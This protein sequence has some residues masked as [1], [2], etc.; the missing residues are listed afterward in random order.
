M[1]KIPTI[2]INLDR[3]PH[4][5]RRFLFNMTLLRSRLQLWRLPAID[6]TELKR[7]QQQIENL[8]SGDALYRL[9]QGQRVAK[10]D[11]PSSGAIGCYLSHLMALRW[12]E[13][14][15][16]EGILILED[17]VVFRA[18]RVARAGMSLVKRIMPSISEQDGPD[19]VLLGYRNKSADR[20]WPGT[21]I[22]PIK[23]FFGL[24]AYYV[25]KQGATKILDSQCLPIAMQIDGHIGCLATCGRLNVQG[26]TKPCAEVP[27]T[28][29]IDGNVQKHDLRS[30]LLPYAWVDLLSYVDRPGCYNGV[31]CREILDRLLSTHEPQ[32]L[33]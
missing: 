21:A 19:L 8:V 4:R 13:K 27:W 20:L 33:D 1:Y 31:Q 11:L 14:S 32:L 17:D 29:V 28:D 3:R 25:T 6:T 24:Y 16:H 15:S 7:P 2:V 12:C 26:L 5:M 18:L 23:Q 22:K 9:K 10:S 30:L